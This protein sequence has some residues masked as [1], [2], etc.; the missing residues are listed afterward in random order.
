MYGQSQSQFSIDVSKVDGIQFV[1][2]DVNLPR[3]RIDPKGG[4]F[5]EEDLTS[6][7]KYTDPLSWV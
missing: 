7:L 5:V 4:R 6:F 2:V 3:R 1:N